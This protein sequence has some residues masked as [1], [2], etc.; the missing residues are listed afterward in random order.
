MAE[1][2]SV[3]AVAKWADQFKSAATTSSSKLGL[4][5]TATKY[6]G[7][8]Q[9]LAHSSG[10]SLVIAFP[11]S[12]LATSAPEISVLA[13]LLNG[14]SHVKWSPGFSLLSKAIGA[15]PGLSVLTSN[16]AYSDAGLFT[17][18]L[19]GSAVQVRQAAEEAVKAIKSIAEGSV[20]KEDLA[21]AVARAKFDALE[22]SEGRNASLLL[23]GSGLVQSGK[24]IDITSAIK[25]LD[26]VTAEKL[27][28]VCWSCSSV[29][30]ILLTVFLGC[31]DAPRWQGQCCR[32]RRS[33]CPPVRRGTWTSGVRM[34]WVVVGSL[35]VR[36]KQQSATVED[37]SSPMSIFRVVSFPVGHTLRLLGDTHSQILKP[38]F[39]SSWL[40][41]SSST[42]QV[43]SYTKSPYTPFHF[44]CPVIPM[45]TSFYLS[46]HVMPGHLI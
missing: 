19:T 1:G 7:G 11:G 22:A 45:V 36:V 18:Q 27:K 9:R 46:H 24:P 6:F 23:A 10:N 41:L 40:C 37:V 32:C 15:S 14:Q 39:R 25:P 3:D 31:Q 16:L 12:D 29:S 4:N 8:E 2:A 38:L 21:K 13:A 30:D 43:T 35:P 42:K 34:K 17:I 5:T 20:G 33:L 26:S 44:G 28:T